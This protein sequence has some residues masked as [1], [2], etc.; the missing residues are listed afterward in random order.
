MRRDQRG[1]AG[2]RGNVLGKL[3]MDWPR[4]FFRGDPERVADQRGNGIGGYDLPR[5]LGQRPHRADNIDELKPRLART[6][7][8]LL[9]RYHNHRHGAEIGV[10]RTRREIQGSRPEG[11][12][13]DAR[14]PG[15]T[16]LCRCHEG[17]RLFVAGEHKLNSRLPQGLDD[18]EVSS[19]GSPKIR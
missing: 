17:G 7:D 3:E 9:P 1:G 6:L 10:G 12:E 2:F 8:R 18:V 13:T 5:H 11:G 19:P 4:P 16:S 14:Q 15:Q